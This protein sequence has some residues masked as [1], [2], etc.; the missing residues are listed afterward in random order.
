M[1]SSVCY[2]RQC[3]SKVKGWVQAGRLDRRR[4]H[5]KP[6][7]GGRRSLAVT[8]APGS[9][10]ASKMLVFFLALRRCPSRF[11]SF[12]V[13]A[14]VILLS[15]KKILYLGTLNFFLVLEYLDRANL[16]SRMQMPQPALSLISF[17]P[18]KTAFPESKGSL[19]QRRFIERFF[20]WSAWVSEMISMYLNPVFKCSCPMRPPRCG[21]EG[22][23]GPSLALQS[24]QGT[25]PCLLSKGPADTCFHHSSQGVFD[26]A[27]LYLGAQLLH[28][29]SVQ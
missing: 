16:V 20:A 9:G 26:A 13:E 4:A 10:V 12:K 6:W 2:W 15:V 5:L 11:L 23:L 1:S 27:F 21:T 7:G 19:F 3:N 25:W 18:E 28:R 22:G 8:S 14:F 24:P 17:V 29:V